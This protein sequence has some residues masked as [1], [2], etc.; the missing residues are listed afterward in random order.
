[1]FWVTLSNIHINVFVLRNIPTHKLLYS[2]DIMI[3]IVISLECGFR[4]EFTPAVHVTSGQ[5]GVV[6]SMTFAQLPGMEG[7]MPAPLASNPCGNGTSSCG[8]GMHAL[9]RDP[10]LAACSVTRVMPWSCRPKEHLLRARI[11]RIARKH[12]C[13][14]REFLTT[15]VSNITLV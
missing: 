2:I 12:A 11:E 4:P 8:R 13:T 6:S 3:C 7:E 15:S 9:T 10:V 1:M 5:E 14:S